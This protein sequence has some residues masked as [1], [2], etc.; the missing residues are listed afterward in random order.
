MPGFM[1][2]L[3]ISIALNIA[4]GYIVWTKHIKND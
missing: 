3:A 1:I 2:A 4:L